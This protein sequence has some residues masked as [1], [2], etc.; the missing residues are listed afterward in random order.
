[1]IRS[2]PVLLLSRADIRALAIP[3]DYLAAVDAGFRLAAQGKSD[4]PAPLHLAASH[5]GF[6]AKA[7]SLAGTRSYAAL[8]F[9]GNFPG[10]PERCG[11]PTIQG[12]I[13]LCDAADGT[14]LAVM[15]SQEI[16]LRRTAAATALAARHLARADSDTMTLCGC[17]A[18]ARAQ[19]EALIE[20]LPLRACFAW[21][22][23]PE[24]AQAFAHEMAPRL[25]GAIHVAGQLGTA[26]RRSDVIVTCTSA[27][28]PFLGPDEVAA[29]AFIAAVGA[30]SPTKSELMPD[31][32]AAST[33]VVDSLAQCAAMG[34]LHHALAAQAMRPED[35]HAELAEV[36]VQARP[37]RTSRTEIVVFDSTGLAI[38]DVASAA[39]LFERATAK[40]VGHPFELA[41]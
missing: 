20:V 33:V 4:V 1:V 29:G 22:L 14:L 5:G 28:T 34:D 37:G 10:N 11:K 19:F 9:N 23:V 40:G 27:T 38:E 18:Q 16:T 32:L 2:P 12:A 26:T 36:V 8:K 21:D 6:H 24:R 35:V 41:S 39:W 31:L 17:G 7:A 13:L 25:G 15:D 3:A 30:D